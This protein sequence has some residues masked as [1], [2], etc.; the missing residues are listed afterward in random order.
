MPRGGR[1]PGAGAK[2]GNLNALRHGRRSGQ[3]QRL[4]VLLSAIPEVREA[5][6]RLARR[7]RDQRRQAERTAA[8]ILYTLL[9]EALIGL[10]HGHTDS[11]PSDSDRVLNA[12][13]PP[14]PSNT[15][16][17]PPGPSNSPP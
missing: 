3:V 17:A 1:R 12:L 16:P 6:I 7:Q 14:A 10:T 5:L 11:Q 2:P 4:L 15:E 13:L 8:H 9:N